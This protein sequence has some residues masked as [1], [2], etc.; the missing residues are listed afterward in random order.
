MSHV[1]FDGLP[2]V[3]LFPSDL[4]V[5]LQQKALHL[6]LTKKPKAIIA[7]LTRSRSKMTRPKLLCLMKANWNAAAAA[8]MTSACSVAMTPASDQTSCLVLIGSSLVHQ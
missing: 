6:Y 8:A 2:Q 4:P 5:H 3:L 1:Y 7:R